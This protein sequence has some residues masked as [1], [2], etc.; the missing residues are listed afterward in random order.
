MCRPGLTF[1]NC[2]TNGKAYL[3]DQLFPL[4]C[5]GSLT[6]GSSA[7]RPMP[8]TGSRRIAKANKMLPV[9]KRFSWLDSARNWRTC[10]MTRRP[11]PPSLQQRRKVAH[12]STDVVL[13][14]WGRRRNDELHC[15][16]VL[17]T[18]EFFRPLYTATRK[19]TARRPRQ[20]TNRTTAKIHMGAARTAP[21]CRWRI[22][23]KGQ[24]PTASIRRTPCWKYGSAMFPSGNTE[25]RHIGPLVYRC[26]NT[27]RRKHDASPNPRLLTSGSLPLLVENREKSLNL[28]LKNAQ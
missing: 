18:P 2:F 5:H 28:R 7:R 12:A 13:C 8:Y 25:P 23:E 24:K 10:Q 9:L 1:E 20:K 14:T 17:K 3:N 11:A 27:S 15:S 22:R 26:D 19:N 6:L 4:F 16:V 21:L